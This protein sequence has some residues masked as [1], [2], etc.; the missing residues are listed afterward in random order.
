[1]SQLILGSALSGFGQGLQKVPEIQYRQALMESTRKSQERLKKESEFKEKAQR[2]RLLNEQLFKPTYEAMQ[3]DSALTQD[4]FDTK[5]KEFMKDHSI[6]EEFLGKNFRVV[7]KPAGLDLE[8]D[9]KPT[10]EDIMSLPLDDSQKQ[11]LLDNPDLLFRLKKDSQTGKVDM[12]DITR[13]ATLEAAKARKTLGGEFKDFTH[14]NATTIF[15]RRRKTHGRRE[16][17][18][19]SADF[20]L[21]TMRRLYPNTRWGKKDIIK[22]AEETFELVDIPT[23]AEI[24][25]QEIPVATRNITNG[26][27]PDQA[28]PPTEP[29]TPDQAP[30]PPPTPTQAEPTV[31]GPGPGEQQ[32]RVGSVLTLKDGRRVRVT[33]INPQTG[34]PMVELI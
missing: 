24:P 6:I 22:A 18:E 15:D 5:T 8:I 25:G 31:S 28:L 27:V 16:T 26:R 20:T 19:E 7:K 29:F 4:D 17:M 21:K 14:T 33:S 32:I 3:S 2:F 1:M 30:A 9:Y 11:S 23:E 10:R 12:A 34:K 13:Q